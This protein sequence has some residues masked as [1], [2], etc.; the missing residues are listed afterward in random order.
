MS[1]G[2][3]DDMGATAKEVGSIRANAKFK[4]AFS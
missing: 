2:S 4:C 3:P 1:S